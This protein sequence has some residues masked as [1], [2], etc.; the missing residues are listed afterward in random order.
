MCIRDSY[1]LVWRTD[2]EQGAGI[3]NGD[4][5]QIESINRSTGNFRIRFDDKLC[6]YPI[7]M[8]YELD[9]AYAI[10][11]HKSQGCE[12]EAVVIPVGR[13]GGRLYYRNLL[14]TAVTRAKKLLVLVGRSEGVAE[15]VRNDRKTL[16]YTLLK[17]ML[18]RAYGTEA[19]E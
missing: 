12:F 15:M 11:V 3:Y 17:T 1:D 8:A 7:A 13:Q 6:D 4:I 9:L 2:T 19:E 5:G 16:R 14:Y 18:R 10:T